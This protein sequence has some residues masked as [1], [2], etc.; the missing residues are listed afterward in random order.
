M[1]R[2][3]ATQQVGIFAGGNMFQQQPNFGANAFQYYNNLT[4]QMDYGLRGNDGQNVVPN[5]GINQFMSNVNVDYNNIV[6]NGNA[7]DML[8]NI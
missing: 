1:I 3:F 7:Q 5:Q 6:N 8:S 2:Q 4:G